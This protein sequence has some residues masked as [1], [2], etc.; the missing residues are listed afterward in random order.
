[1]MKTII[2]KLPTIYGEALNGSIYGQPNGSV[3][4]PPQNIP[5]AVVLTGDS[6]TVTKTGTEGALTIYKIGGMTAAYTN[7]SMITDIGVI[8][9]NS[10]DVSIALA[11]FAHIPGEYIVKGLTLSEPANGD[12]L[13]VIVNLYNGYDVV[14]S[15]NIAASAVIS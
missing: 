15:D 1:M 2:Q 9:K 13:T 4:R 5:A 8:V 3:A 10:S 11:D 12:A 6:I 14:T 7:L